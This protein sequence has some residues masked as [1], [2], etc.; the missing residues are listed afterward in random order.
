MTVVTRNIYN[1]AFRLFDFLLFFL[2]FFFFFPL[3]LKDVLNGR[4]G[5]TNHHP[6]NITYR[7]LV[8]RCREFYRTR[9][10]HTKMMV[11]RSIVRTIANFDEPGRF[12]DSVK[13]SERRAV[14]KVWKMSSDRRAVDKVSQALREQY[15]PVPEDVRCRQVMESV[16]ITRPDREEI[17]VEVAVRAVSLIDLTVGGQ[18]MSGAAEVVTQ[19]NRSSAISEA[20]SYP[21]HIQPSSDL[22]GTSNTSMMASSDDY[23]DRNRNP[24]EKSDEILELGVADSNKT[25]EK[26]TFCLPGLRISPYHITSEEQEEELECYKSLVS[27]LQDQKIRFKMKS[28][29]MKGRK[30]AASS[31]LVD[32]NDCYDDYDNDILII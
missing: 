4:G 22:N 19:P 3:R 15:T 20:L 14:G 11:A 10:K 13:T 6:G 12:L 16:A 24:S 23:N 5:A 8:R 7:S 18:A 21:S 31:R 26:D 1:I 25:E 28:L 17:S 29:S 9:R 2:F 27:P 30:R 32:F